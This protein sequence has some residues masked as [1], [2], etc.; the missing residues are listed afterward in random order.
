MRGRKPLSFW[1]DAIGSCTLTFFG[2]IGAIWLLGWILRLF[3]VDG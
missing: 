2:I 3:G 1:E